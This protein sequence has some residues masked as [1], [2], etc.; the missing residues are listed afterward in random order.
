MALKK[1]SK[2][3]S[4][5]TPQIRHSISSQEISRKRRDEVN[6]E[7]DS[8]WSIPF[9]F[10]VPHFLAL[11]HI[12]YATCLANLTTLKRTLRDHQMGLTDWWSSRPSGD[13]DEEG[14]ERMAL[15]E[16]S[17]EAVRSRR[18]PSVEKKE[19]KRRRHKSSDQSCKL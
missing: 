15:L 16:R 19:I 7:A 13:E 1:R 11:L 2:R 9:A 18:S 14:V 8:N 12:V 3:P 4:S 6:P 17:D 5:S 10:T